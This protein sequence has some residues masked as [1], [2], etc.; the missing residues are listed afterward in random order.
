[1]KRTAQLQQPVSPIKV[2][3]VRKTADPERRRRLVR[4]LAMLLDKPDT[5]DERR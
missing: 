1:M 4:L 5:P 2:T 3:I